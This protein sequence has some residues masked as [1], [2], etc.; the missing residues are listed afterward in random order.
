MKLSTCDFTFPK[1]EWEQTLRLGRDIGVEAMDIALFEGRSHLDPQAVLSSPAAWAER[2]TAA[3]RAQ[4]LGISDVFGQAGSG[5]EE[6]AVNDPGAEGRRRAAEFFARIL[7]FTA[8]CNAKH[9]TLLPGVHLPDEPYDDSLKRSAEELAWRADAARKLGIVLGVEPHLG[10]IVPTPAGARRLLDMTPGLTLTLDYCHFTC[11]GIPDREVEP[12]LGSASHFHARGACKG[13][14]Q[15]AVKEN[16][17]DYARI[18][19]EMDRTGYK[20]FVALEYVWIEWMRCNEVDNLSE[21]ILLRDLLR[22]AT[23]GQSN[24]ARSTR[25]DAGAKSLEN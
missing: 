16:T 24:Q 11:Q 19:S 22:A 7:E 4:E 8:R 18:L 10:S 20:G 17:V 6:N 21:T 14:L 25:A 5:A 13:K 9:L 2:I 12:L 3:F 15:A 23:S 1:L